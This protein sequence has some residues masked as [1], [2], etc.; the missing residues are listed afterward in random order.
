MGR[1]SVI[2]CQTGGYSGY[3]RV[4]SEVEEHLRIFLYMQHSTVA[5]KDGKEPHSQGVF[6]AVQKPSVGFTE[7]HYTFYLYLSHKNMALLTFCAFK[8]QLSSES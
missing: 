2:L 5:P 6:P 8:T 7:D 1:F 4:F 3:S